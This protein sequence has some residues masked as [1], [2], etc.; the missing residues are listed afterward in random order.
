MMSQLHDTTADESVTQAIAEAWPRAQSHWSRFLLL[1]EPI[2]NAEQEGIARIHLGTRQIELNSPQIREKDLIDCIEALLAHEVGHHVRYPGSLAVDARLRLIERPLIPIE[3]YSVINLFTDLL[4]NERLGHDL[5]DQLVRIYQAFAGEF[6]WERDPAFLFYL[7]IYEELWGLEPGALMGNDRA[8]FENAC[9]GARADA[10]VL[11]QDLFVL[12]PNLYTQ[13]LYFV[14]VISRYLKP[15]E[16]EKREVTNPYECGCAD[17]SADDWA[18]ALTPDAREIE[19]I[20]R[21]IAEGWIT[22]EQGE[23]LNGPDALAERILG[24]PGQGGINAEQVPEIM[25]AYY[26][27]EAE[28]YLFKPPPQRLFGDAVVP[29]T[30]DDWEP[31]DPVRDIDWLAT[32][33]GRGDVLGAVMPQKRVRVAEFEGYD[34]PFWQ[35][36]IEVYLDVSGS[37]PDPRTARNA[38]TLAAQILVVAAIRAGGWARALL[39]SGGHVAYW[40]WCR[41]EVEL[42]RFLMHYIGGG[43]EF[44]F[45]VLRDSVRQCRT[46]QP[47]RVV[48]TD[49]DFDQNYAKAAASRRILAEAVSES[50]QFVLMMHRPNPERLGHY[51]AL[52]AKGIAIDPMDDFPRMAADLARALFPERTHGDL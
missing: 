21:A 50:P 52:G 38:M 46:Q 41:S 9:P 23:L 24:L 10:Q 42:S 6:P 48:I 20:R 30:L 44:P 47:I 37:M 13:F 3:G 45:P 5:Q 26:R 34:V 12:G 4:I 29:T 22:V 31:G 27:Q 2:A 39:Y 28:K 1:S 8:A 14:S 16:G 11:S 33:T 15:Q 43:T 25:A 35:P 36:R 40:T 32:L 51:R 49:P 17:P 19:A 7:T 18:A